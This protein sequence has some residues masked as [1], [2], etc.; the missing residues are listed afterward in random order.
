MPVAI[1][2]HSE[3]ELA[4]ARSIQAAVER[5]IKAGGLTDQQIAE[6][7]GMLPQGV[8]ILRARVWSLE[9][10]WRVAEALGLEPSCQV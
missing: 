3:S 10:A 9:V 2:T 1:Y 5:K 8:Q 6:R 7:L 4:T